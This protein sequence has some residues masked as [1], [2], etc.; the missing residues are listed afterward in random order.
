LQIPGEKHS[1][2]RWPR[3]SSAAAAGGTRLSWANWADH[4]LPSRLRLTHHNRTT[5]YSATRR[6]SIN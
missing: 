1:R 2:P 6:S 5:S 3:H 4:G